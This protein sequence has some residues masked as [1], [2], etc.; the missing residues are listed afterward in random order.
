MSSREVSPWDQSG[1]SWPGLRAIALR[2]A[3]PIKPPL[4]TSMGGPTGCP[5]LARRTRR[6]SG[7][8]RAA[9]R[10]RSGGVTRV[11]TSPTTQHQGVAPFSLPG[12]RPAVTLPRM[13]PRTALA[14]AA[15]LTLAGC[16]T[17]ATGQHHPHTAATQ[18][19]SCYQ[20]WQRWID[21]TPGDRFRQMG[22]DLQQAGAAGR[23]LDYTGITAHDVAAGRQARVLLHL[24]AAPS[25][26]D[27]QGAWRK[28]LAAVVASADDAGAAGQLGALQAMQL[29]S[30]AIRPAT[31]L[32]GILTR[33]ESAAGV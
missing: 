6:E 9:V 24:P 22:T 18:P 33:E 5:P 7:P 28:I 14:V 32:L 1:R 15:V 2:P 16:G 30:Q 13:Q 25:C 31:K 23:A 4:F 8:A 3:G 29:S 12:R 21:G 19:V 26:V 27:R 10:M 11:C 17:A 20:Q